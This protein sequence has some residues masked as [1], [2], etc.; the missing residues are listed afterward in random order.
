[1]QAFPEKIPDPSSTPPA[2]KLRRM[3]GFLVRTRLFVFGVLAALAVI[4]AVSLLSPDSEALTMDEVEAAVEQAMASA[5]PPPPFSTTVYQTILPSLVYIQTLTPSEDDH[6]VGVGTGV[7]INQNAEILTAYHVIDGASA[8]QIYFADGTEATAEVLAAD[9][10][11]DIA[12][13]APSQLPEI[14][15][16]AVLGN[17]NALRIGDEAYAVGNPFGLA[18]SMSAGV[19]S[20]FERSIPLND[21]GDML[22]GLIQFDTAVNPGN[23]GGPLLNRY[24][25]VVGIVTALANPSDQKFFI[26]IGFAVSISVAGGA[27]G[28]PGY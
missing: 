20:G 14:L 21:E 17:P 24:G 19:I 3:W 12:V 25:Q 18:G 1:M 2:G 7:V 28:A 26:G 27:A 13:L 4:A 5:T 6:D 15:V 11:N 9:P 23:S 16:P 10:S 22:D 8:I